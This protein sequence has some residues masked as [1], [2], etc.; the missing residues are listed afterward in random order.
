MC[1]LEGKFKE[2]KYKYESQLGKMAANMTA[3]T[4][5][6]EDHTNLL[7][8]LREDIDNLVERLDKKSSTPAPTDHYVCP[9]N[10]LKYNATCI[11][12]GSDQIT[13]TEAKFH[14]QMYGAHLLV[15]DSEEL[16]TFL[17]IRLRAVDGNNHYVGGIDFGRHNWIWDYTNREF[18]YTDW[19]SSQPSGGRSEHCM[20]ICS[21]SSCQ[22]NDVDCY[23]QY[24]YI[25]QKDVVLG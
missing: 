7:T 8:T 1:G 21:G 22:W 25:C 2:Q 9:A 5:V 17:K 15:V 14:C 19:R 4:N 24:K 16:N 11:Y 23:S 18:D 10:W 13:W 20:V 12:F 3:V 6:I